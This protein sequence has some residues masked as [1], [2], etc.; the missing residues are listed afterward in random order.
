MNLKKFLAITIFLISI[1]SSTYGMAASENNGESSPCIMPS[2]DGSTEEDLVAFVE[3]AVAYVR[4]K[5]QDEAIRAFNDSDGIFIKNEMYIWAYDFNGTTLA[6]PYRPDLV[7]NNN[8]NLTDINGVPIIK[9]MMMIAEKGQGFLYYVWPNP[10][11]NNKDEFKLT[12]VMKAND[13]LWV[14]SGIY[15]AV[16]N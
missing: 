2:P 8:I 11:H 9:N 3:E 1:S 4:E 5:G 15:L 7:G 13:N 6:H 10:R 12:Y 16:C 14:G